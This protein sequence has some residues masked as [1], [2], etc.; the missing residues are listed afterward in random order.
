MWVQM[1]SKVFHDVPKR[2]IG[3]SRGFT[4]FHVIFR[5]VSGG[6]QGTSAYLM[7]FP[8]SFEGLTSFQASFRGISEGFP[9]GITQAFRQV[10]ERFQEV[11]EAF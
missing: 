4:G 3:V 10:A 1:V 7:G 6:F 8:E 5:K 11:S 9:V 2:F